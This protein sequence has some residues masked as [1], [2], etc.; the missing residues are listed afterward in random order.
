MSP[1]YQESTWQLISRALAGDHLPDEFS[2]GE[3]YEWFSKNYPKTSKMTVQQ[4]V[5]RLTI[6]SKSKFDPP[7]GK[8]LLYRVQTDQYTRY[9]SE[10]HGTVDAARDGDDAYDDDDSGVGELTEAQS[11]FALENH[12]EEFMEANWDKI[13][14]GPEIAILS[15]QDEDEEVSGR[16][17]ETGVGRIDFLCVHEESGDYVVLELKKGKTS[18]AVVGQTLRYMGWVR[19]HVADPGQDVRGVIVAHE[20]DDKLRYAVGEVQNIDL[21]TYGVVFS[22]K[23]AGLIVAKDEER[24]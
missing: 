22:L 15:G 9:D 13:G 24:E 12:L 10:V 6:N 21:M 17:F 4:N 19:H 8:Y 16:Q 7:G 18:D 20:V 23:A 3:I 1:L 2:L 11:E 14:L 5:Q